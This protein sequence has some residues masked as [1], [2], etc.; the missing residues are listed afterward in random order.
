[1]INGG[2]GPVL[3]FAGVLYKLS[4]TIGVPFLTF[5]GWC[6][7]WVCF[8]MI[9]AA[10]VDLNRVI[11]YATRFTDEIFALLI[12]TIFIIDALGSPFHPVG[13]YYYFVPSY[14]SHL[15]HED[16]EDYNYLEVAFLSLF[17]GLGTT[18]LAYF[19][20]GVKY[21]PFLWKPWMRNSCSD[22]SV[23]IAILTFSLVDHAIFP[24]IPTEEL[25]VPEKLSPSFVCCTS[26]CD[27]YFPD[28]CPGLEE[29]YGSRSWV[30]DFFDLNGK[31]YVPILAAFPAILAFILIFLVS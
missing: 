19:L 20:R 28:D 12:A 4:E 9:V 8:Y 1:M 26:S 5:N 3:A 16:E 11:R 24:S 29:P 23:S 2:T 6:G 14:E 7:M 30:V 10:V 17:L 22:F 15:E 31:A 27:D 25:K 21:S 18:I 13:L